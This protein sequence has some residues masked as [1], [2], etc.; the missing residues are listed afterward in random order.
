MFK[1]LKEKAINFLVIIL[2]GLFLTNCTVTKNTISP[3]LYRSTINDINMELNF[4]E[5]EFRLSG[6]GYETKNELKVTGQSYSK[7]AGYGSL[8]DNDYSFYENYTYTDTLGNTI[9]FQLKHKRGLDYHEKEYIYGIEVIKC[10]CSEKKIYDKVCANNGIVKKIEQTNT[11][12]ESIFYDKNQTMVAVAFGALG[13]T[14][15]ATLI[16]IGL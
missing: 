6:S 9:E 10:Y 14:L 8:I 15:L 16:L 12:Q 5:N 4:L 11:D 13:V 3:K 7:Y 1:K 2:V